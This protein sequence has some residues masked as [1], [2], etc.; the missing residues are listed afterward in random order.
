MTNT[1]T[2]R[3]K[4]Q[5]LASLRSK[6]QEM[7]SPKGQRQ[8]DERY[9]KPEVDKAGSGSAVIR[10]LPAKTEEGFPFVQIWTHGFQGPTGKWFI[11]NCPTSIEGD[12]PACKANT[13]L[14][15]TG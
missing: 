2:T 11:D 1:T 15:S 12:C 7:S 6:I 9:W 10:F 14:W 3:N 4:T 8:D 5:Y 13:E